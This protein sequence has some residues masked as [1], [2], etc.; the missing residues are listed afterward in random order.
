MTKPFRRRTGHRPR[1]QQCEQLCRQAE[2]LNVAGR[3]EEALRSGGAGDAPQ[4]PLSALLL[5]PIGL[6]LPLDRAVCRGGRRAEGSP[7]AGALI[8]SGCPPQAG[9]QLR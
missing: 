4:P 1:S 2:V 6:G 8:L 7:S 3:P 9:F 5:T